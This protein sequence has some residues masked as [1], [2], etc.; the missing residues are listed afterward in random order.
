MVHSDDHKPTN[1][2][3]KQQV[4]EICKNHD[5]SILLV[6][7]VIPS[8]K[9][10][11]FTQPKIT[12]YYFFSKGFTVYIECQTLYSLMKNSPKK[13]RA[14]EEVSLFQDGQEKVLNTTYFMFLA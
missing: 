5:Q 6:Y 4:L 13:T 9:S 10:I 7:D 2:S 1:F 14:T 8:V 11:V 12:D 3:Q